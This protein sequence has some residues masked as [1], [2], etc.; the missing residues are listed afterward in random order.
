MATELI[1]EANTKE[2]VRLVG[3]HKDGSVT[4]F[5]ESQLAEIQQK[6]KAEQE[7]YALSLV[8]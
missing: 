7:S 1:Y 5:S 4:Y 2:I 8:K 6:P 3:Y